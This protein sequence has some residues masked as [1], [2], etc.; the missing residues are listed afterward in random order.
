MT[1]SLH[2][3]WICPPLTVSATLAGRRDVMALSLS[4]FHLMHASLEHTVRPPELEVA[5]PKREDEHEI[6]YVVL[7]AYHPIVPVYSSSPSRV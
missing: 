6:L 5:N 3:M 2:D 7:S 1:F 4:R